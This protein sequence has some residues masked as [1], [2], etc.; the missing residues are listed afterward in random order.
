MPQMGLAHPFL[1]SGIT[2]ISVLHLATL[3]PHRK[4]EVQNLA[5]AHESAA[6]PS[7]RASINNPNAESIHATFAYAGSVV[8]YIMALPEGL[9][10]GRKVNRCMIPS[11]DDEYPHWFQTMRGLMALLAN[12]CELG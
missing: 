2:A 3:L 10:A 12:H 11:K 8:Y 6:L 4:H 5:E 9:H 7:F 1:L